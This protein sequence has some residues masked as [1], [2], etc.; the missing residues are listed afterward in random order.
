LIDLLG[1]E[2]RRL[3]D[4]MLCVNLSER[5]VRVL[6]SVVKSE[7]GISDILGIASRDPA[8]FEKVLTAICGDTA[9][10]IFDD[11]IQE[12]Y[13]LRLPNY[14]ISEYGMRCGA[15]GQYASI[16]REYQDVS[17]IRETAFHMK[18]RDH[19]AHYFETRISH[20]QVVFSFIMRGQANNQLNVLIINS[21]EEQVFERILGYNDIES[22]SLV[23]SSRI[24]IVRHEDLYDGDLGS[25]FKPVL[26]Q[27]LN[28]QVLAKSKNIAGLN[29]IGTIAGNLALDG[30]FEKCV[31]IERSWDEVIRMF[32][33]PITLLCPYQ[34]GIIAGT[35][36][37]RLVSCHNRGLVR[38]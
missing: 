4:D 35:A 18:D 31:A 28:I 9:Y 13:Q 34:S 7:F 36:E 16:I 38:N 6:K 3:V 20:D 10:V 14:D 32:P 2:F 24:L 5:R 30:Q 25:S 26:D 12:L 37:L 8:R 22:D 21:E 11:I 27:L 17:S 23:D 15:P 19:L 33:I 1:D 29:I